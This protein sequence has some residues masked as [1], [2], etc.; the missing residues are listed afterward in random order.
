MAGR[1]GHQ[2]GFFGIITCRRMDDRARIIERCRDTAN[3]QRGY[4][5]VLEDSD[6]V[7][8]LQLVVSNRRGAIDGFLR[9]RFD[10][11]CN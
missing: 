5:V 7:E 1:F 10:E 2:R 3:D 11:V 9:S 8:M 6:I 4:I